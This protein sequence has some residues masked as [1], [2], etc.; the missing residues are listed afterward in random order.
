MAIVRATKSGNWS[1]TTVWNTAALPT[2]A[3]DVY[4]NT[5][6]V[7][8]DQNV[9]VLSIRNTAATGVTAG[10]TFNCSTG[11]TIDCSAGTGFVIGAAGTVLL[12]LSHAT[13][14]TVTTRG[15]IGGTANTGQG[16]VLSSTGTTNHTGTITGTPSGANTGAITVSGAHTLNVT[17]D[18]NAVN[19]GN[20]IACGASANATVTI[21]GNMTNATG[22][23]TYALW[24]TSGS[25]GTV[26]G[27]VSHS[28]T[29]GATII[30]TSGATLSVTG[31]LSITSSAPAVQIGTGTLV[32]TGPFI[33]SSVGNLPFASSPTGQIRLSAITNNEFRFAQ[34]ISGTTS[35]YSA[36]T[37]GGNP[38]VTNVRYGTVYGIGGTLTGTC[39]VPAASSVGY[40]VLV[41]NTTGTAA[42]A[43]ADIAAVVGA[44]IAASMDSLP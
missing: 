25:T 37:V 30:T 13:G 8:I 43:P 10:G 24:L 3:D 11:R 35:L 21:V 12:T 1:D 34:P 6:T 19:S 28:F 32:A 22:N 39:R 16:F 44:Q 7:T 23:T 2:S 15:A 29:G 33:C 20:G 38:A 14:T 17:G 42:L 18:V 36:D 27:N 26:T 31:T 41:D 4:S 40:G 9:T 5:Y